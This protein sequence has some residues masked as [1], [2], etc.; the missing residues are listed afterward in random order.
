MGLG[1]APEAEALLDKVLEYVDTAAMA[2]YRSDVLLACLTK[3][4]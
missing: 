2:V 4:G 1:R 3:T